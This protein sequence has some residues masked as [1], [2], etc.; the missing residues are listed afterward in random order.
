MGV[1]KEAEEKPLIN[2]DLPF[3]ENTN[4]ALGPTSKEP[5]GLQTFVFNQQ[6]LNKQ[7]ATSLIN[8]EKILSQLTA[9]ITAKNNSNG[10][11]ETVGQTDI[12]NKIAKQLDTASRNSEMVHYT[13]KEDQIYDGTLIKLARLIYHMVY[14]VQQRFNN[15]EQIETI[16]RNS[17]NR[18]KKHELD[19]IMP[20]IGDTK[21]RV[22]IFMTNEIRNCGRHVL[23]TEIVSDFENTINRVNLNI[24]ESKTDQRKY[25]TILKQFVA[26]MEFCGGLYE[27]NNFTFYIQTI[28]KQLDKFEGNTGILRRKW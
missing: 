2:N 15:Y 23:L 21:S 4:S 6:E 24:V 12:N 14:V 9:I 27:V 10:D 16:L 7:L 1:K 28:L 22:D 11:R 8:N 17:I 5:D 13:L 19:L 18:D 25:L 3:S 26:L 20:G